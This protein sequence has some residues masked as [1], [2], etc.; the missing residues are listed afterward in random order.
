MSEDPK[1]K[2]IVR[3]PN[4]TAKIQGFELGLLDVLGQLGLPT[5]SILVPVPERFN[6]FNN[7]KSVIK[8]LDQ[9]KLSRSIYITKFA[10]AT[11]VG[12]FDAALNYLWD[13]TISELRRRVS[14]YDLEY[15]YEI[16]VA[17]EDKRKTLKI[18]DDLAKIDDSELIHGCREIGLIS[19]L[20]FK[21]LDFI[22]YMR[23]WASA[24]HPNQN[25]INGLQLIAMLETCIREVIS[26]PLNNIVV[27]IKTLL[28]NIKSNNLSTKEAQQI[29]TFFVKLTQEQS[30]NLASGF[31]GLYTMLDTDEQT[32]QNISYLLP[33]LWIKV[34]EQTKYQFGIKFGKFVANN[35]Q[36][37][38]DLARKFLQIV[39]AES[40]ISDDLR[41]T[42]IKTTIDDLLRVHRGIDNFYNEPAYARQLK[43]LVG[44]D[45]RVPKQILQEYVVALIEVFLTNGN[46]EAWEAEPIYLDLLSKFDQSM[47][48]EAILSF[49]RFAIASKLQF[50]L[51]QEKFRQLLLIMKKKISSPGAQELVTL[52]EQY[53]GPLEN[54]RNDA[55]LSKKIAPFRKL[56]K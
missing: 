13:E 48:L 28:K 36:D 11:A 43:R 27:E 40:Y 34:D 8:N 19:D 33:S 17:N 31:F 16:A 56:L 35:E 45:G 26:L 14:Q 54:M 39:S 52:I 30:N 6:V 15:F 4:Y 1:N 37:R 21:Q 49:Q 2:E 47:A 51:C 29:G 42:D 38:R 3:R 22:R 7:L 10:A 53:V 18:P 9:E 5:S 50:R 41:A 20:G 32:R 46:G 55:T 12:L 25:Q 44:E 24:A 23:N